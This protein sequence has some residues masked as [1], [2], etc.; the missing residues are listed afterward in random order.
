MKKIGRGRVV[1]FGAFDLFHPGHI[2][3]LKQARALG[4]TLTVIV[5]RDESIRRLKGQSSVH[6]EHER[7]E[8]MTHIDI[9]DEV[10]LGD[11]KQGEYKILKKLNP[12]IIAVGYDQRSLALSLKE[13][14]WGSAI[15]RLKPYRARKNKSGKIR[16]RLEDMNV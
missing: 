15:I 5:A 12:D 2:H 9:V 10:L 7:I 14:G 6:T 4:E 8:L 11:A 16:K 1:I 3:A 13:A